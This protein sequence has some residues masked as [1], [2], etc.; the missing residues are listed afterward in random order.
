MQSHLKDL[1][2]QEKRPFSDQAQK[3]QFPPKKVSKN[4][5]ENLRTFVPCASRGFSSSFR[6][7]FLAH[8]GEANSVLISYC[9]NIELRNFVFIETLQRLNHHILMRDS[10]DSRRG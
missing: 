6:T 1:C 10:R 7:S 2:M 5:C 9:I 3:C 8:Q 4:P